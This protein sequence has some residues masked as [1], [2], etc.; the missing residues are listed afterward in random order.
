MDTLKQLFEVTGEG[1][2]GLRHCQWCSGQQVA[3]F[4][5]SPAML[6]P[7]LENLECG[8]PGPFTKED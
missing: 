7:H 3:L 2:A 8:R 6:Q 4:G 1:Q 5:M